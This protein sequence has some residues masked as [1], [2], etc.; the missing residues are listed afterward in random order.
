MK[1]KIDEVVRCD[2]FVAGNG[3]AGLTA[4]LAMAR[5]GHEV[6]VAAPR[7][8]RPDLRTTALLNGSIRFLE[9]L[10][11][12]DEARA[13]AF[14]LSVMRIVDDTGRL[15]RAPQI[16]FRSSEIGLEAF[17]YNISNSVLSACLTKACEATGKVRFIDASL[18]A[19]KR[20]GD[21]ALI[22]LS[23][24]TRVEA[25]LAIG[26]DGRQSQVRKDSGFGERAWQYP[27]TAV[28][29][30]FEHEL[31]HGDTSTEFHT[32]SGP[33]TV[34]P[35]GSGRSGLVWVVTPREAERIKRLEADELNLEI[36]Q[37]MQSILGKV[38]TISPLQAWPLAGMVARRFGA[39]PIVLVG[40]A[41][42]VVPPIGAQG[43]NLGIRD[44]ELLHGLAAP[45]ASLSGIG[46]RYHVRRSGDVAVRAA[47]IDVLNRSL[48][49]GF[50]PV[51][52]ARSLALYLLGSVS[53]LRRMV[54][55]EGVTPG[56]GLRALLSPEK[57]RQRIQ[58]AMKAAR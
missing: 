21:R 29:V 47:S 24:K 19:C 26:A 48:L 22:D 38:K 8:T 1:S 12:W 14:P 39:G 20:D 11:A 3:L 56:E 55:R 4:A 15:V 2:V 58:D 16:D 45:G 52:V 31:P 54:M 35:N 27:Q 13:C 18:E 33:F 51:Q 46:E 25:C 17:G 6:L 42:H 41:A 28:V 50:L 53:P 23:D 37:R 43:F 49:S 32:P 30:D 36:E 34:V 57:A 7:Q 5:N 9:T 40:E 10:D 44:V